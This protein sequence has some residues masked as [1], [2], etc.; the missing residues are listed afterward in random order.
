[1]TKKRIKHGRSKEFSLEYADM[2]LVEGIFSVIKWPCF[3]LDELFGRIESI[4]R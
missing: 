3:S 4:A 2:R 1:L